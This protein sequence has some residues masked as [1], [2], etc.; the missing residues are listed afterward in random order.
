[1]LTKK[2][3]IKQLKQTY[4][5]NKD[6]RIA[7]LHSNRIGRPIRFRIESAVYTTQAVTLSNELHQYLFCI[8]HERE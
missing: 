1:M 5:N 6:L 3:N 8:C 2:L 7:F 4:T